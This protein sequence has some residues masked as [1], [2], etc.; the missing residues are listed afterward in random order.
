MLSALRRFTIPIVAFIAE[1][2]L[3]LS[4][5]ENLWVGIGLW[6]VG[7]AWGTWALAT[8]PPAREMYGKAKRLRIIV[9][10]PGTSPMPTEP[11]AD[12]GL[13]D[14]QADALDGMKDMGEVYIQVTKDTNKAGK[15]L[16]KFTRR[17][18]KS[19]DSARTRRI[20]QKLAQDIE[21]YSDAMKER[22]LELEKTGTAV[23]DNLL[24]WLRDER[25]SS[26]EKP[27]T[28]CD[29]AQTIEQF[30][31]TTGQAANTARSTQSGFQQMKG[32][33]QELNQAIDDLTVVFDSCI[34]P[35]EKMDAFCQDAVGIINT[36][37]CD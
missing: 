18:S 11:A 4:G 33:N 26:L 16:A 20:A 12:K 23:S 27:Q 17:I 21:A 6:S 37:S 9:S 7:G 2:G 32:Y 28:L 19:K 1:R 31:A 3:D 15:R 8:W 24:S 25:T 36:G 10:E 35:M 13:F 14:F 34:R 29:F 22:A 30:R 5:I